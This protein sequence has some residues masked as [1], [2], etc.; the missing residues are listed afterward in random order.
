MK[1]T[2]QKNIT[3]EMSAKIKKIHKS[4]NTIHMQYNRWKN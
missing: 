1:A 3:N 2:L 4:G